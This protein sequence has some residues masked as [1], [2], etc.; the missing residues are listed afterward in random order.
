M[1]WHGKRG[2]PALFWKEL[3]L[4]C[5][6]QERW[7]PQK[8]VGRPC[9]ARGCCR[10]HE[11]GSLLS[12]SFFPSPWCYPRAVSWLKQSLK[13]GSCLPGWRGRLSINPFY[14]C[15]D[16]PNL[17]KFSLFKMWDIVVCIQTQCGFLSLKAL[18]L[19]RSP[20]QLWPIQGLATVLRL[21][22]PSVI[23]FTWPQNYLGS[24]T[25]LK[26]PGFFCNFFFYCRKYLFLAS[27]CL[28]NS[29]LDKTWEPTSTTCHQSGNS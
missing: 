6:R 15:S 22:F 19:S 12:N 28:P 27:Q 2:R 7:D 8:D 17:F 21:P 24:L 11:A 29:L 16:L 23:Q 25:I 10:R 13:E 18:P 14:F 1:K 3:A 20:F 9:S 4:P 5:S 26:C